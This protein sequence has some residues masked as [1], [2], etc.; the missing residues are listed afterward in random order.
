MAGI[1]AIAL[2][3][4]GPPKENLAQ[5]EL[6]AMN[7]SPAEF[8]ETAIEVKCEVVGIELVV[9]N[10]DQIQDLTRLT[11]SLERAAVEASLAGVIAVFDKTDG[12]LSSSTIN[13]LYAKLRSPHPVEGGIPS[14]G[15]DLVV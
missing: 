6:Q 14:A 9:L 12:L 5:F 13:C 15:A 1:T 3:A 7:V 11:L 4:T 8:F 2:S 10:R